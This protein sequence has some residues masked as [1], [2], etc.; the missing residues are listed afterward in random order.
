M[1]QRLSRA[2][3]LVDRQLTASDGREDPKDSL[4]ALKE[5]TT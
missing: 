5:A 4:A 2:R 1:R 3:V